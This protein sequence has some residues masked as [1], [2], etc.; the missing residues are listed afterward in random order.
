ETVSS[1]NNCTRRVRDSRRPIGQ[2]FGASLWSLESYA[3]L[4]RQS[5]HALYHRI[6]AELG[7]DWMDR[8]TAEQ[9][10]DAVTQLERERNRFLE[11]LRA[12]AR[13]RIRE[14]AR[15]RRQLSRYDL[16]KWGRRRPY[17]ERPPDA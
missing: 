1:F 13:R 4:S 14:K 16:E 8:P 7:F 17:L 10:L 12:F 9:L 15:G 3:Y 5:F 6:G 2:R 11:G